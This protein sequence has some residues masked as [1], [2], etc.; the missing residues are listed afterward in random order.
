MSFDPTRL[1]WLTEPPADF[2]QACRS[3]QAGGSALGAAVQSLA[4]HALTQAEAGALGKAIARLRH[5]DADL[6]P[7]ASIRLAILANTTFEIIAAALPAAAA[8]HGVSLA[9]RLAPADQ[10]EQQALDLRSD[11]YQGRPDVALLAVDHRWLALDRPAVNGGEVERLRDASTR[12]RAVIEAIRENSKAAIILSTLPTPPGPLFGSYDRRQAG[13]VRWL[14]DQFNITLLDIAAEHDAVVVDVA[15]LAE[16]VGAARWFDPVFFNLYKLPFSPDVTALYC[17]YLARVLGALRGKARKCLVLDLDN[18]CWGGVIGDDGVDGIRIGPGDPEGESYLS[19]QQT[20]VDLKSRGVILAVSS[21]N[22]DD[23]A[24]VP[25]RE[26]RGMLLRESDFAA[27]Q[28]NW[29]DKP[30]NL[31]TIAKALE[32]GLDALVLLDD[33][34]AERAQ[35]RAA[36][37]MVAVP[38]LPSDPALFPA[39]LLSAGYFEAIAFSME[40]R[41]RSQSYAANALRA[42]A[43]KQSRNLGDYLATL[44]MRIEFAPF[45]AKGR[46]RIVQ[47]VNKSNQFNLTSRRYTLA[48][49]SAFADG[50][51]AFTLQTRLADKY[52]DFGMVGV[53]I[54][55][56]SLTDRGAVWELDTW[57]MSCRVLGRKVEEAMLAQIVSAARRANVMRLVGT[58]IPTAKNG[59]VADHYDKLGFTCV[60]EDPA[61]RRTYSLELA[62]HVLA[63]TPFSA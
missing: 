37:P 26:H 61:G 59:M 36:L 40:D 25:F 54:A 55:T 44:Q 16:T 63:P 2:R 6:S 56:E 35:V 10:V 27:F 11:F 47:L 43:K 29:D 12:L 38:E 49:I 28:A 34:S 48:E 20:A 53:I 45:D 42:E 24:R 17:D 39:Y 4:G 33:N 13:S 18:T 51:A 60:R 15:A 32:I 62:S 9:L 14:T 30:S 31:E 1:P 19:I 21:K 23:V 46:D 8:R 50:D 57:L 7:L 22:N 41:G 5:G 52:G 58:Y 3:L